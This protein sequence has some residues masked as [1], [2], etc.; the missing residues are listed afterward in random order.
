MR[1][2]LAATPPQLCLTSVKSSPTFTSTQSNSNTTEAASLLPQVVL[3]RPLQLR[4][5]LAAVI[6]AG[7]SCRLFV[8]RA[9]G[10][11]A[12][13]DATDILWTTR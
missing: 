5:K 12:T 6:E 3:F 9:A 10:N 7:T 8:P 2:N 1:F 11:T 4:V 13:A